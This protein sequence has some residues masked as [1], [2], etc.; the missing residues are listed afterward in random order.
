MTDTVTANKKQARETRTHLIRKAILPCAFRPFPEPGPVHLSF[1]T[2]SSPLD[3]DPDRY[4]PDPVRRCVRDK[5]LRNDSRRSAATF[6]T[7]NSPTAFKKR[8]Q[9]EHS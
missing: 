8:K 7:A 3:F 2:K 6:F 5:Q 4:M 9:H 1:R